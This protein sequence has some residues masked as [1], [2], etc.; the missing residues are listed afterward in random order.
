MY[1]SQY[2][3]FI[4]STEIQNIPAKGII[5]WEKKCQSLFPEN[6]RP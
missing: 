5:I 3:D 1:D 4:I 6:I 2:S